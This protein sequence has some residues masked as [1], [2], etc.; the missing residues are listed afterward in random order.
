MHAPKKIN[1]KRN[2]IAVVTTGNAKYFA[3]YH[4]P[5]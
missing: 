3:F 4:V 1:D 2:I 5:M